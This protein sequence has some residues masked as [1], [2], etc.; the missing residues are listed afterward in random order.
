[1]SNKLKQLRA[2]EGFTII[3]VIIVLVIGA[4]IMLAVF[5]VVPQ[6]QRTQRNSSRQNAARRVL[7]AGEQY[8]ANNNGVYPYT[9]TTTGTG[10]VTSNCSGTL[11]TDSNCTP[12]TNITGAV[13]APSGSAYTIVNTIGTSTTADIIGRNEIAIISKT[14]T[15]L[16]CTSSNS[17]KATNAASTATADKFAVAVGLETQNQYIQD[18][19]CVS[20]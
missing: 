7:A 11:A 8:A 17:G 10:A 20:N 1:M 15:T 2:S 16:G 14:T 9:I 5:L 18:T 12:I 3:E 13:N 6:L 4:V 19:F